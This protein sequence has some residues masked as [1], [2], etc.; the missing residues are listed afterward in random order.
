MARG[1]VL[2]G[3]AM[4]FEMNGEAIVRVLDSA[5]SREREQEGLLIAWSVSISKH[6]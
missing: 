6:F 4:R 5:K 2:D 3:K 1:I